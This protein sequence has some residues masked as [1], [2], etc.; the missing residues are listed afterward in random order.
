MHPVHYREDTERLVLSMLG[1]V[2]WPYD[3]K[4]AVLRSARA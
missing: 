4:F 3:Y 1:C 2:P